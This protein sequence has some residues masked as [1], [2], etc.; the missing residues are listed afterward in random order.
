MPAGSSRRCLTRSNDSICSCSPCPRVAASIKTVFGS[1]GCATSIRRW[2][3]MSERRSCCATTRATWLRSVSSITIASSAAPSVRNWRVRP[4]PSARSSTPGMAGDGSCARRCKSVAAS[5]TRCWRPN[6]GPLSSK[7]KSH[8]RRRPSLSHRR[9]SS[10]GISVMSSGAAVMFI[11]TQEYSRFR[12]F[13][14]ACRRDG[15]IGLCYG[16]AGVG[17]TVSARYY[18]DPGNVDSITHYPPS[19]GML[20]K[21]PSNKVAL[22]TPSVVNSPGHIS[23]DIGGCRSDFNEPLLNRL[24]KA[25]KPRLKEFEQNMDAKRSEAYRNGVIVDEERAAEFRRE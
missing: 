7:S 12:E 24:Y 16:T 9:S 25:E 22:Y 13:C 2:P 17:K 20:E 15:Y 6:A 19:E 8:R 1:W 14:D 4:W 3:R 21:G 10:R 23:R 18:T 11:E 5:W